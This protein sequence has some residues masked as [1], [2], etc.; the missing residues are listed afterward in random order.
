MYWLE[1]PPTASA[2][3]AAMRAVSAAPR[4]PVQAFAFPLLTTTPREN[5]EASRSRH[6]STGA[7]WTWLVVNTPATAAGSS[8]T[9]SAMSFTPPLLIPA[10][11]PADR[12]PAGIS[13]DST[14]CVVVILI[15][16][17]DRQY[18]L[19]TKK[20]SNKKPRWP[21]GNRGFWYH[22]VN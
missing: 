17:I 16:F 4:D 6:Q 20:P 13:A 12:N 2:V 3:Q 21:A 1:S 7:A 14:I 15:Y 18:K 19:E 10:W 9:H 22:S 8:E 11:I 5:P